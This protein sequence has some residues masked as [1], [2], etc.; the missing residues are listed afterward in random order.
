MD[1]LRNFNIDSGYIRLIGSIYKEE[2]AKLKLHK[3]SDIFRIRKAKD[4][5]TQFHLNCLM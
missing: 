2:T 5:A 3:T 4:K 1:K